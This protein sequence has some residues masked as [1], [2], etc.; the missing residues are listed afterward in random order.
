[1]YRGCGVGGAI[2][3]MGADILIVDDPV[4]DDQEAHSQIFRE[5]AWDWFASTA[6]TRLSEGAGIIVMMTRWHQ[7]DLVGRLLAAQAA[8]R[9]DPWRG[10]QFPRDRRTRRAVSPNGRAFPA[11]RTTMTAMP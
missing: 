2:T 3:G 11:R 7:D 10:H 8:G 5:R 6:Y 9:G 1:M 4:K